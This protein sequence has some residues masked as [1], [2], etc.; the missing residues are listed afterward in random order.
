MS[1]HSSTGTYNVLQHKVLVNDA[2]ADRSAIGMHPAGASL[3]KRS[4]MSNSS[5]HFLT[6]RFDQK[7]LIFVVVY[8]LVFALGL[9]LN[10]IALVIFIRY[11]KVRSH[12]TVYMTNLALADLLL[13]S[14]LPMRIYHHTGSSGL[15]QSLCEVVGLV[16][17]VNMYGSIFLLMCISIDRCVAVCFPMSALVKEGRKKAPLICLGVWMLTVGASL[18]IYLAKKQSTNQ[19]PYTNS[20]FGTPPVYATQSVAIASTLTVGFG[21]P[22]A[23]MLLCSWFLIRTIGRSTVAQMDLIDSR[24]IRRMIT[25]SLLLFLM[26]FLPYHIM[27]VLLFA[28]SRNVPTLL[29]SAFPYSLML[30]CLNATL[31][32]IMYYFTTETFR[33]KVDKVTPHQTWNFQ[34]QNLDKDLNSEAPLNT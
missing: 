8:S 24:K 9:S 22:L 34:G 5:D 13:V 21:I 16:L 29:C 28:Y 12:T 17:L 19:S 3:P 2:C 30:A 6:C 10:L 14:T 11:T 32:P 33:K 15:S 25:A 23:T 27:L 26:C 18:P 20:C 31:D 4:I 7:N 1:W